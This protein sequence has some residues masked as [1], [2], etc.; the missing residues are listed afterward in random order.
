MVLMLRTILLVFHRQRKG[1]RVL[2]RIGISFAWCADSCS[3][4]VRLRMP[5]DAGRR[6]MFLL[7]GCVCTYSIQVTE[8][9]G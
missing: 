9:G 3:L 8:D 1:R 2:R 5:V 7:G 4:L 6:A